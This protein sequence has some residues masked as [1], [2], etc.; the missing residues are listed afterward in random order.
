MAKITTENG[1]A[2][3][4]LESEEAF[5]CFRVG[6]N[7]HRAWR[8]HP[9]TQE[10]HTFNSENCQHSRIFVKYGDFTKRIK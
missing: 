8:N 10:L 5:Q 9:E 1:I 3:F 7:D 2:T 4:E 6:I